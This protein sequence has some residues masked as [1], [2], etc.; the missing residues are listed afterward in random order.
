MKTASFLA[1]A[2]LGALLLAGC[3]ETAPDSFYAVDSRAPPRQIL[4]V[5]TKS[6]IHTVYVDRR[7]GLPSAIEKQRLDAFIDDLAKDR[8]DALHV[9]LRGPEPVERLQRIASLLV[10][11]GV[12]P[13]KIT[14][15]PGSNTGAAPLAGAYPVAGAGGRATAVIPDCPGWVAHVAA[16]ADNRVN[17]NFGCTD[18]SNFAAMVADPKDLVRGESTPYSDGERA[19][20]AVSAYRA[21]KVKDL[22]KHDTFDVIVGK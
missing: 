17:P 14:I 11:R 19:A 7:T 20:S 12:E 4:K 2:G 18:A 3:G 16:P 8:P 6:D 15:F 1:A 21:D 13:H 5:D 22:P 9:E 10:E